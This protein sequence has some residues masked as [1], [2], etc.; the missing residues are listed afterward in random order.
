MPCIICNN[1]TSFPYAPYNAYN[2][3]PYCNFYFQEEL[4][5]KVLEGPDENEGRGPGT[6]NYMSEKEK[7][8][9]RNLAHALYD[10]FIPKSVLDIGCKYPYFLSVLKDRIE[11][12]GI[13]PIPDIKEYG[14]KLDVPVLQSNFECMDITLYKKKFDLV[15]I[16]HVFEHFYRPLNTLKKIIE[17]LTHRG[18]IYIRIPNIDITGIE[19]D[20]TDHHLQ[21]HPFIYST[22]A[23]HL[24]ARKLGCEIFRIDNLEGFGQSDFYLRKKREHLSLS[25]CMIVKN[26]EKNITDCLDSIKDVA[27]EIIIVDTGS[28]DKTKEVVSQYNT[29]IFDFKW[30][31]DF[32]AARN[33]SLSKATG[34]FILWCFHPDT[35]ICSKKGYIPIKDLNIGDKVLS[36]TGKFKKINKIYKREFK[37]DLFK[38]RTNLKEEF[39]VTGNHEF[40]SCK[41]YQCRTGV[42]FCKPD[43]KKQYSKRYL[44]DYKD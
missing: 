26:E 21:I 16:I 19:R 31:D 35:N 38:V 41:N 30:I 22:Q 17:C 11:V 23:M 43:C 32:S 6:G 25:V 2:F 18:V 36:H 4:P 39:I 33:F 20:F 7:E 12:L 10:L 14:Q 24:I 5:I 34:D 1:K 37:G 40:F 13:D 3:C 9:N 15:T 27:D 8:V 42:K 28:T 29:Q 44:E